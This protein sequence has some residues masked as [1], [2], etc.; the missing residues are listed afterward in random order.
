MDIRLPQL[1]EGADSGTVVKVFV[2]EGDHVVKDQILLELENEKAVAPIPSSASGVVASVH[3]KPGDKVTVGQVVVTLAAEG[4]EVAAPLPTRPPE[5]APPT[6]AL[7]SAASPTVRRLARE[8]GIDLSNIRGTGAGGRLRPDDLRRRL[9][10]PGAPVESEDF[11]R[12]GPV[13]REPC[14]PVRQTIAQRMIDSWTAI[15]H[16]TQFD[17]V[18]ATA[19]LNLVERYGPVFKEQKAT[20]TLTAIILKVLPLWLREHRKL[21]ASLDEARQEIVYK[22][23]YHLGIAVDTEAGLIVPVLRDVDQK[24]LLD[25]AKALGLLV[26]RTRQRKLTAEDMQGGTFT[27]SNQ[28]SIGGTHFTP[29]IKRPEVA[30]LGLGRA[31]PKPVVSDGK[32][33]V[34]PVLPVALSYDH[35]VIDGA[36]AAR[37]ITTLKRR[38]EQLRPSDVG[39]EG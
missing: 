37:G 2:K 3:I 34:R 23:Y 21:N 27:V 14:S 10:Q 26:E 28:G 12:W 9:E 15:P 33:S 16:V 39:L 25:L 11:S 13:T 1:G 36:D 38:L 22:A 7:P 29:I 31:V 18:D 4:E 17:E 19:L 5:S 24:P 30:I 32:I 20:L 35:R 8:L 6:G